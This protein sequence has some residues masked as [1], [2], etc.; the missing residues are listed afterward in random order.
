MAAS[1]YS[2]GLVKIEYGAI[3][4]DGGV[5]TTWTQISDTVPG[6]AKITTGEPTVENILIE[7]TD[8]PIEII[9]K[10]GVQNVLFS[11]RDLS[12]DTL[13]AMMGGAK[14]AA[15]VGPPAVGET[16]QAPSTAPVVE[17]SFRVT[18]KKGNK[19]ITPRVSVVGT[20]N[21]QFQNTG[22]DTSQLDVKG[23]VLVPAKSGTSAFYKEAST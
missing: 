12:A 22:T 5:A 6:T 21:G 8:A 11:T 15:V 16:W 9:T 20:I 17:L 2:R 4:G 23:T 10:L 19:W 3:A 7:E 14:V 18:D 13:V 1:K